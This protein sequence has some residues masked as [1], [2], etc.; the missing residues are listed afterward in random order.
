M[1]IMDG[2]CDAISKLLKNPRA[3]FYDSTLMDVTLPRLQAA[4]VKL[5]SF[6]IYISSSS[7]GANDYI[8]PS[9]HEILLSIDLYERHILTNP[10]MTPI[11]NQIDIVSLLNGSKIGAF[12]TLEGADGLGGNLFYLRILHR[13]GVRAMGLTWNQANWAAD[14]AGEPRG[15]GLTILGKKL[16]QECEKLGILV[17]VSHLSETAFWDVA[18]IAQKPFYASHSNVFDICQHPRNLKNNQIMEIIRAGGCIGLTFVPHFVSRNKSVVIV[19]LLKHIDYICENGG[20]EHLTFG[21]DFDGIDEWI[22]DL[23]HPGQYS[24]L[25]NILLRHY[26]ETDV[27][28][29]LWK[30]WYQFLF[31]NI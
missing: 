31:D 19:D 5:Q 29:W 4:N 1:Y 14:G 15:G 12:L 7:R 23:E 25:H 3:D 11:L 13:L 28:N 26:K 2:H 17:D 6:A 16:V 20:S 22:E 18:T 30:N 27:D 10:H 9:F 8:P 24:N 21:S